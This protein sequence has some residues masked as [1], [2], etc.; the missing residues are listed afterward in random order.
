MKKS[1][2]RKLIL[3]FSAIIIMIGG[4]GGFYGIK[5]HQQMKNY[6]QAKKL[7]EQKEYSAAKELFTQLGSY[8]AST[9]WVSKCD[10]QPEIDT[11]DSLMN[12]GEYE[13]ARKIYQKHNLQENSNECTYQLAISYADSKKYEKAIQEFEK[14]TSYK[15][16]E[17]RT[18]SVVYDYALLLYNEQKYTN[19]QTCFQ[20]LGDYKES[21][22]FAKKCNIGIKYEKCDTK[23]YQSNSSDATELY[24]YIEEQ[25]VEYFY[26][27]WYDIDGKKLII[28]K[29]SINGIP[30]QVLSIDTNG[31]Y[32]AF[33]FTFA[34]D[35]ISHSICRLSPVADEEAINFMENISFDNATYYEYNGK[36]QEDILAAASEWLLQLKEEA[37][38]QQ[39]VILE[40]SIKNSCKN[41]ILNYLNKE[42]RDK[43]GQFFNA[44]NS[45]LI[46]DFK[47]TISN[48]ICY[49]ECEIRKTWDINTY[50]ISAQYLIDK[51]GNIQ[52]TSISYQ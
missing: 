16:V 4:V 34:N 27:T 21:T 20:S 45:W 28:N 37:E 9:E 8:Q 51:T 5:Q 31:A 12:Q 17:N 50:H 22:D 35:N 25:L 48:P 19:A 10:I 42:G 32:P 14:I 18:K 13:K 11:A 26:Q 39:A 24:L 1:Q 30:Y 2:K 7:F 40:Q 36:K 29:D 6:T 23:N 3:I 41:D 33:K 15:D 52:R 43:L 38:K 49:V 47:A 46:S 44:F